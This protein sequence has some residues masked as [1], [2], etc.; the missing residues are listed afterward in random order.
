MYDVKFCLLKICIRYFLY[1]AFVGQYHWP[2]FFLQFDDQVDDQINRNILLETIPPNRK[3]K[4]NE[5]KKMLKK[6][7]KQ[8]IKCVSRWLLLG[9]IYSY[10]SHRWLNENSSFL[11]SNNRNFGLKSNEN[12]RNVRPKFE[13][14]DNMRLLFITDFINRTGTPDDEKFQKTFDFFPIVWLVFFRGICW[15]T[16]SSE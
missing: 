4:K 16:V 14:L 15:M 2:N 13:I 3:Q 9:V 8:R 5:Q 12:E 7:K 11:R 10:Q 1:N 6:P